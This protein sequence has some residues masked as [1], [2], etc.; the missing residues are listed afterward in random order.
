MIQK[1]LI[2]LL[3]Q[4]ADLNAVDNRGCTVLHHVIV[5]ETIKLLVSLGLDVNAVDKHGC[6]PLHYA[7]DTS[8]AKALLEC[9][10]D[11][12]ISDNQGYTPIANRRKYDSDIV[13]E[14]LRG[15]LNTK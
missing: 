3:L 10:A 4:G 9:G 5:P 11:V 7:F 15:Y 6:T 12:T 13:S 1:F 2:T 14:A 8:V